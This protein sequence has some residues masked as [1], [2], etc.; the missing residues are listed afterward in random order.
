VL[1][2]ERR[3]RAVIGFPGNTICSKSGDLDLLSLTLE[4]MAHRIQGASLMFPT[5]PRTLDLLVTDIE[6]LA[7]SCFLKIAAFFAKLQRLAHGTSR[8]CIILCPRLEARES[9][10]AASA[11]ELNRT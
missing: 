9:G 2:Q 4:R 10:A 8:R 11:T 3:L 7:S 1:N 6:N 5:P